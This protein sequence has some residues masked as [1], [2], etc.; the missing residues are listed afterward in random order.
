MAVFMLSTINDKTFE[1]EIAAEKVEA[2]MNT[3]SSRGFII[4]KQSSAYEDKK[5]DVALMASAIVSVR[6]RDQ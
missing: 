4:G 1:L 2:V 3:L 6:R 5:R